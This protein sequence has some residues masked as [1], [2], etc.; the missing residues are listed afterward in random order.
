MRTWGGWGRGKLGQS[1]SSI[2]I[3]TLWNVK[4]IASGKQQHSTGRSAQ[5]FAM[6]YRGGIGRVGVRLKREGIWGYMY[7]YG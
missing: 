4:Q 5:C 2:D 6:T 7:A 3:Y 1:E